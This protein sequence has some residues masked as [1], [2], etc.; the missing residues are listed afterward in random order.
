MTTADVVELVDTRAT[1]VV[2]DA[3][4]DTTIGAAILVV[5]D[6]ERGTAG[7]TTGGKGMSWRGN[8]RMVP[9]VV[10]VGEAAR[11]VGE[12]T[13]MMGRRTL[14]QRVVMQRITDDRWETRASADAEARQH[15]QVVRGQQGLLAPPR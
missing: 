15:C 7:V 14:C 1:V 10:F 5:V 6:G 4:E 13:A 3:L 11:R 9:V 2:S 12:H 8:L